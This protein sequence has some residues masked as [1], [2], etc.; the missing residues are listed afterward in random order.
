MWAERLFLMYDLYN[1]LFYVLIFVTDVGNQLVAQEA[2]RRPS[3]LRRPPVRSGESIS[4]KN[5]DTVATLIHRDTCQCAE[6]AA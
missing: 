1:D 2:V 3:M 6:I 4:S 5:S